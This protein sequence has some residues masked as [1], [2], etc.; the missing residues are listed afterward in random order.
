MK[1]TYG[2]R[3]CSCLTAI[4]GSI[5]LLSALAMLA[6][7]ESGLVHIPVF[8]TLYR[9]PSPIRVIAAGTL[10]RDGILER[11]SNDVGKSLRSGS[12]PPYRVIFTEQDLTA[13][14]KGVLVE[15]AQATKIL[16]EQPQIVILPDSL[17]VSGRYIRGALTY[18]ILMRVAV[19]VENGRIRFEPVQTRL[20]IIPIPSELALSAA[21]AVLKRDV[22]S[23][24]LSF[25]EFRPASI[26]LQDGMLT[27]G[28]S[29]SP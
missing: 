20:G 24:D 19:R 26:E 14:W 7:A 16:A 12:R 27:I 25:G 3:S 1:R 2:W 29:P 17:E 6:V 18:D 4:V 15:H 8:S 13:A 22:L 5:F 10:S 28:L 21:G 11:V 23:L 9:R